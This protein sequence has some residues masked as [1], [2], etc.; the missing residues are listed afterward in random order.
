MD[1]PDLVALENAGTPPPLEVAT[2]G[3]E[4]VRLVMVGR[5]RDPHLTPLFR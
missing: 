4:G 1:G 5:G 2:H 3:R